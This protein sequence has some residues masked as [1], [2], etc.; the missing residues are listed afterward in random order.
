MRNSAISVTS[1]IAA[2]IKTGIPTYR[3]TL[4]YPFSIA[5]G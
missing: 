5:V 2:R 3:P 4:C 1:R